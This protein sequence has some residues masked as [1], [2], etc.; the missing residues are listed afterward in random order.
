MQEILITLFYA[1]VA[2]AIPVVST[3]LIRYLNERAAQAKAKT[4]SEFAHR[5]IQEIADAV[6]VA[7]AFVSQT[8]VDGLKKEKSFGIE[9]HQAAFDLALKTTESLLTVGAAHFIE[10]EYG[11]TDDYLTTRIEAEVKLQRG[12]P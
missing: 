2:A 4:Q 7:V 9:S 11:A 6:A 8:L 3:F 10:H 12:L 5:H 1:V